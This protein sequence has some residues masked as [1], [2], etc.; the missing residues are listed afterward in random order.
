MVGTCFATMAASA[1]FNLI[2]R[3][4]VRAY[5]TGIALS[6]TVSAFGFFGADTNGAVFRR[7]RLSR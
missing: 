4:S 6:G 1:W 5:D 7:F 2:R 3:R